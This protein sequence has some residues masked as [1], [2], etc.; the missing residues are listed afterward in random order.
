MEE[1][2]DLITLV[3]GRRAEGHGAA[4]QRIDFQPVA[5]ADVQAVRQAVAD[6]DAVAAVIADAE[7]VEM[8]TLFDMLGDDRRLLQDVGGQPADH[9]RL[10][11]AVR[12]LGHDRAFDIGRDLRHAGDGVDAPDHVVAVGEVVQR[13]TVDIGVA[14][15]GQHP[16]QKLIAEAVHDRQRADQRGDRQGDADEADNGDDGDTAVLAPGAQILQ[17]EIEF[18]QPEAQHPQ[19]FFT[20]LA[21]AASSDSTSRSPVARCLS[22]TVPSARPFGPMISCQGMPIRSI[23]A[24]LAP[25]RSSVSL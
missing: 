25:G 8:A 22:S 24:N 12:P 7:A 3:H 13:M 1:A 17:G 14:V 21:S 19:P 18:P 5:D 23:E 11:L 6:Q 15:E 4:R 10:G 16:R 9:A 20:S 2:D